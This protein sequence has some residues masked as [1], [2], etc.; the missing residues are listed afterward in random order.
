VRQH[1][2]VSHAP[3]GS[4]DSKELRSKTQALKLLHMMKLK[5]AHV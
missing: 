3:Q 5:N 1:A 4:M 2:D